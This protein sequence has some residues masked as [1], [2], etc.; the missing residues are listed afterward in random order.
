MYDKGS[1]GWLLFFWIRIIYF[2]WWIIIFH[3][4]SLLKIEVIS[5]SIFKIEFWYW[6]LFKYKLIHNIVIIIILLIIYIIILRCIKYNY[7]TITIHFEFL[8]LFRYILTFLKWLLYSLHS[9]EYKI[10]Y[11]IYLSINY[12]L[13]FIL[14]KWLLQKY[15]CI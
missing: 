10:K 4:L 14:L 7:C 13:K 3:I 12:W 5:Y 2:D 11:F 6:N 1:F 15:K 9:K 8:T